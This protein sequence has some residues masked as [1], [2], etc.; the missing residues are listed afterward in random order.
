M[1]LFVPPSTASVSGVETYRNSIQGFTPSNGP[2][3][4]GLS[5]DTY[6]DIPE[7]QDTAIPVTNASSK[8]IVICEGIFVLSVVNSPLT[9]GFSVDGG[10]ELNERNVQV[11]STGVYVS[12][13][14]TITVTGLSAGNHSI[15]WRWKVPSGQTATAFGR[16]RAFHVVVID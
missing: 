16:Q 4:S 15:K 14:A 8:I 6:G 10:A 7:M 9:V 12:V 1:P 13:T 3:T 11:Q 2:T 5:A